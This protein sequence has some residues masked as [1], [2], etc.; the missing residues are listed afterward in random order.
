[1]KCIFPLF[2]LLQVVINMWIAVWYIFSIV[3]QDVSFWSI[4]KCISAIYLYTLWT[5]SAFCS[6][7]LSFYWSSLKLYFLVFW[8]FYSLSLVS[9]TVGL[10]NFGDLMLPFIFCVFALRFTKFWGQIHC[11]DVL[12]TSGLKIEVF[13]VFRQGWVVGGFQFSFLPLDW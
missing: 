1:M 10:L 7:L 4:N 13:S 9:D 6:F 3:S 8:T 11:L 5:H 12:V 2:L